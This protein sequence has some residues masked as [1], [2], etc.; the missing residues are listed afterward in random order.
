MKHILF[1]VLLGLSGGAWADSAPYLTAR[2]LKLSTHPDV[3]VDQ[4]NFEYDIP[5][6]PEADLQELETRLQS[7]SLST[8][9]VAKK[10]KQKYPVTQKDLDELRSEMIDAQIMMSEY[11]DITKQLR[12]KVDKTTSSVNKLTTNQT[13]MK[14]NINRLNRQFEGIQGNIDKYN[15]IVQDVYPIKEQAHIGLQ[16]YRAR[17]LVSE[18]PPKEPPPALPTPKDPY[19]SDNVKW[20]IDDVKTPMM[21]PLVK[22]IAPE[23]EEVAPVAVASDKA[24]AV[25]KPSPGMVSTPSPALSNAL[26]HAPKKPYVM[27]DWDRLSNR[28]IVLSVLFISPGLL[29][30]FWYLLRLFLD[31]KANERE[32]VKRLAREKK[33]RDKKIEARRKA[34]EMEAHE[35]G[36]EKPYLPYGVDKNG[37]LVKRDSKYTFDSDNASHTRHVHFEVQ[38]SEISIDD[39]KKMPS[40]QGLSEEDMKSMKEMINLSE[41]ELERIKPVLNLSDDAINNVQKHEVQRDIH[42]KVIKSEVFTPEE[43]PEERVFI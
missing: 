1:I 27:T 6:I 40:I 32:K 4:Q 38:A 19:P 10:E 15:E 16:E 20:V 29:L 12:T 26:E 14:T 35:V 34:A 36:Y 41:E 28:K 31:F 18:L 13:T 8:R 3:P 25:A 24:P 33:A 5:S 9:I 30:F 17:T 43:K 21:A 23:M 2:D 22:G 42:A 37:K 7:N 11:I 39:F